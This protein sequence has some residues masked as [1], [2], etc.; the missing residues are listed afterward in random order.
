MNPSSDV[1]VQYDSETED[2][3]SWRKEHVDAENASRRGY[4]I[5]RSLKGHSEVD[6]SSIQGDLSARVVPNAFENWTN[7]DFES[8]ADSQTLEVS[9]DD[10]VLRIPVVAHRRVKI[11]KL[12]RLSPLESE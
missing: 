6:N 8:F 2:V 5:L 12:R 4:R 11:G 9:R 3:R 1:S 10:N 7:P